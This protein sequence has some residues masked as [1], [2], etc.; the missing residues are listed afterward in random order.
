MHDS[1]YL[2]QASAKQVIAEKRLDKQ[3]QTNNI[4]KNNNQNEM[5]KITTII[6]H[7]SN[8]YLKCF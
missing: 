1:T 8:A 4:L 5:S 3:A 7:S 2:I 6:I